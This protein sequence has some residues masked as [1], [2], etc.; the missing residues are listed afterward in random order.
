MKNV[1][2]GEKLY[3]FDKIKVTYEP[4]FLDSNG[5]ETNGNGVDLYEILMTIEE[6]PF[7]KGVESVKERFWNMFVVDSLIGN[8]DRNKRKSN[9]SLSFDG[10]YEI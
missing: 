3:E 2:E 9:Q 8:P 1:N 5:S 7:L 10:K 6:H 4:H